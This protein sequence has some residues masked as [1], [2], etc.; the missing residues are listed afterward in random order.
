MI[1]QTFDKFQELSKFLLEN[2]ES[3]FINVIVEVI[4]EAYLAEN[5]SIVKFFEKK[6]LDESHAYAALFMYTELDSYL[7]KKMEADKEQEYIN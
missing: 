2:V 7:T 1:D 3:D 6:R 4:A 5:P